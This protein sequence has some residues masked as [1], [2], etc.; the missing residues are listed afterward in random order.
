MSGVVSLRMDFNGLLAF[1]SRDAN[2]GPGGK[3]SDGAITVLAPD[4][5]SQDGHSTEIGIAEHHPYLSVDVD[6]LDPE[7]A[8]TRSDP[9]R[10]V[11][12]ETG[13]QVALWD[14][15][16]FEVVIV[17]KQV[18]RVGGV[19]DMGVEPDGNTLE[20][21]LRWLASVS[22]LSG[23][24]QNVRNELLDGAFP[25]AL[26][27]RL[28]MTGGTLTTLACHV[29]FT[30]VPIAFGFRSLVKD[31]APDPGYSDQR[32]SRV[33]R[34][35]VDCE[36]RISLVPRGGAG[37]ER[38]IELKAGAAFFGFSSLERVTTKVNRPAGTIVARKGAVREFCVLQDLSGL[39]NVDP[40]VRTVPIVPL[41]VVSVSTSFC[42]PGGY[43]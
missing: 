7:T 34:W 32:L 42:P 8:E 11:A 1:V 21:S 9:D 38:Y 39:S 2:P 43:P 26:L 23:G 16:G 24:A 22:R 4:P 28:T 33:L 15:R 29:D 37:A 40:R 12:L 3:P 27:S 41:P 17:P 20:T 6:S 10:V 18:Q 5:L 14:V 30:G 35:A 13:R 36:P 31:A 19:D 25:G